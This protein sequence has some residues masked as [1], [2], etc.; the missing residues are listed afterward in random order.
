[1]SLVVK[2]VTTGCEKWQY[3]GE[4]LGVEQSS[5]RD[6]TVQ[7]LHQLLHKIHSSSHTPS[8]PDLHKLFLFFFFGIVYHTPLFHYLILVCLR[9]A[10]LI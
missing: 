5:L 10:L 3:I 6:V 8:T 1:M 2:E 4:E 9:K 7:T